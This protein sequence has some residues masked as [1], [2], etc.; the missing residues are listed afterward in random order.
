MG[1]RMVRMRLERCVMILYL[2]WKGVCVNYSPSSRNIVSKWRLR[3][4]LSSQAK[5]CHFDNISF[6]KHVFWL[7]VS[8]KE[9]MFVHKRKSLEDLVHDVPDVRLGKQTVSLLHE[10]VQVAFH[11][12]KDKE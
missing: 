4:N 6:H 9:T 3:P 11:V 8:M 10:L 2:C 7:D 12:F 1:M 5:I